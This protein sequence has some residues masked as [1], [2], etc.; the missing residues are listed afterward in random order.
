MEHDSRGVDE[1]L[2]A[3]LCS[4]KYWKFGKSIWWDQITFREDGTGEVSEATF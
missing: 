1:A 4:E 3:I 2:C